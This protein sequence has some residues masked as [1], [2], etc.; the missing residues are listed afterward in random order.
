MTT[1]IDPGMGATT[2]TSTSS[3][4]PAARHELTRTSLYTFGAASS[5]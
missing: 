4:R 1:T 5:A 2:R 3:P